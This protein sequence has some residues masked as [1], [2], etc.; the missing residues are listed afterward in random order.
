[1]ITIRELQTMEE[2]EAAVDVELAVWNVDQRD[3]LPAAFMR[4]NHAAGGVTLG[5]YQDEQMLG[6]C[7]A[8]PAFRDGIP[9]LWSHVTGVL[10]Q[11]Q[12]L[13]IGY[14]LKQKQADWAEANGFMEIHW[15]FD[16]LQA[17]NAHFNL[18][19]LGASTNRYYLNFYGVMR[20]SINAGF[21]SDRVEAAWAITERASR[22]AVAP[23]P[24]PHLFERALAL[25]SDGGMP[26]VRL[27]DFSGNLLLAEL[28]SSVRD[29]SPEARHAWRLALRRVLMALF[30]EGYTATDVLRR[31]E[32]HY[33]VLQRSSG[34]L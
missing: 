9:M 15:T 13:N 8:F 20:D 6:M 17:G 31:G 32:R 34:S 1:M 26:D 33:Y 19:R 28:P 14:Q 16:P 25:V 23:A 21:E 18:R 10:A 29:L 24:P 7:C 11:A 4:A 3:V 2:F 27:D 12:R 5:A 30:A 22:A